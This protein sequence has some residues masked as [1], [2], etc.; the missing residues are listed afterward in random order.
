MRVR[1]RK[2]LTASA[3]S[4]LK[5]PYCR[6]IN[7]IGPIGASAATSIIRIG[8][9]IRAGV[10]RSAHPHR[11]TPNALSSGTRR[12]VEQRTL[13]RTP[14]RFPCLKTATMST[15]GIQSTTGCST[16]VNRPGSIPTIRVVSKRRNH[17]HAS[18][19]ASFHVWEAWDVGRIGDWVA[20]LMWWWT[21]A[22]QMSKDQ[23][24]RCCTRPENLLL[25]WWRQPCRLLWVFRCTES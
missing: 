23:L 9:A 25:R 10:R 6:W 15:W 18:K 19:G 12:A 17:V 13:P 22:T 14:S 7:A 3:I 21:V 16:R 4:L 24:T 11:V 1:R 2:T 5:R 20:C 8:E